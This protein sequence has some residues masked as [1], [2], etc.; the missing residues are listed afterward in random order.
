MFSNDK[1]Y[2]EAV[3]NDKEVRELEI[4]CKENNIKESELW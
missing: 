4:F 1:R 2:E 3:E